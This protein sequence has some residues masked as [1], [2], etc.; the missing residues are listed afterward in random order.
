MQG[1]FYYPTTPSGM[2]SSGDASVVSGDVAPT[3]AGILLDG[4]YYWKA[5]GDNGPHNITV[6]KVSNQAVIGTGLFSGET[7]SGWQTFTF[8][9]PIALPTGD[10][11]RVAVSSPTAH[12]YGG[13]FGS[14]GG[15][16]NGANMP[17]TT[18]YLSGSTSGFPSS[19]YSGWQCVDVLLDGLLPTQLRASQDLAEVWLSAA[20]LRAS[21]TEAE[22]WTSDVPPLRIS[23]VLGEVWVENNPPTNIHASQTLAEV[24]ITSTAAVQLRASQLLAEVWVESPPKMSPR[25]PISSQVV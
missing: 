15:T 4:V 11:Y 25:R 14:G 19:S 3:V 5:A 10:T 6:Y 18:Y 8:G 17:G 22:V 13:S 12:A 20:A 16:L 23:Q 21:Q 24:W 1:S 2:N 9:T 7:A